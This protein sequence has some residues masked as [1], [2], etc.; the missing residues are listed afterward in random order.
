MKQTDM[1]YCPHFGER[2]MVAD[3]FFCFKKYGFFDREQE[4]EQQ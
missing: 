2:M 1:V 3:C 4:K